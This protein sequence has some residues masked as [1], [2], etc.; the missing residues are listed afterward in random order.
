MGNHLSCVSLGRI[1]IHKPSKSSSPEPPIPSNIVTLVDCEAS[2]V[3]ELRSPLTA[4]D[5]MLE[6]P[7]YF[8][9]NMP[10][11][12]PGADGISRSRVCAISADEKLRSSQIY[13]LL[14]MHRLN[15]RFSLQEMA[16]FEELNSLCINNE[17]QGLTSSFPPNK[18]APPVRDDTLRSLDG[19]SLLTMK[20]LCVKGFQSMEFHSQNLSDNVDVRLNERKT[21]PKSKSWIPK[22]ETVAEYDHAR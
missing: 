11:S 3:H 15:T 22:L 13:L 16:F 21:L 10:S 4:A 7:G 19:H 12:A 18:A 14:P 1:R 6:F 20:K 5:A 17:K 8:L 9:G 2:S